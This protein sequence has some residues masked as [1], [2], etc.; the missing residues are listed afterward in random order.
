VA[1]LLTGQMLFLLPSVTNFSCRAF[2]V[3]GLTAWNLLPD[4]RRDPSHS[5][6]TFRRLLK[7]PVCTVLVHEVHQ[8]RCVMRSINFLLT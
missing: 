6:D 5:E 3:A 1:Q 4:Y 7:T 2:T 8:R